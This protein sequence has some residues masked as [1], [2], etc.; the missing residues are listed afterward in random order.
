MKHFFIIFFFLVGLVVASAGFR[1][2]KSE[3]PPI[4]IFDDMDHQAKVKY[5]RDSAFFADGVGARKPLPGTVPMGYE[6]PAKPVSEGAKAPMFSFSQG[7]DFYNTGRMG[8][9]YGDGFP[10]ELTVDTALLARGQQRFR[11]FCTAC[12]GESGNG[13][14]VTSQFG[15][16]GAFNFQQPGNLDPANAAAY[17][18]TGAIFDV[19]TN[20]KGL[21][22]PIK[23]NI[24]VRDRWAIVAY[25]KAMQ[26]AAQTAGK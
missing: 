7:V 9:Y 15:I 4:E 8:D 11:V 1:G 16:L 14:G 5:Q 13:K 19:I 22:G 6:V 25:I 17:R 2:S 18:S 12:H 10:K 3:L 20:G 24:P 23:G 26:V 21:M